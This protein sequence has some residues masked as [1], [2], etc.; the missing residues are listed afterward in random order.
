[1]NYLATTEEEEIIQGVKSEKEGMKGLI[2]G[3]IATT[4]L[5][6]VVYMLIT[7]LR[8]GEESLDSKKG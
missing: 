4:T 7:A 6:K 5:E 8:F 1:M 2:C 3:P